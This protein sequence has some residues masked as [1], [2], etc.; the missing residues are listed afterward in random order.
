MIATAIVG[1]LTLLSAG[2]TAA[3]GAVIGGRGSDESRSAT[4]SLAVEGITGIEIDSNAAKLSLTYGDVAEAKLDV[5]GARGGEWLLSREDDELKV[6]SPRGLFG[7]ISFCFMAC[8]AELQTVTLTLPRELKERSIDVDAALGAG[9]LIADGN[10][11]DVYVDLSAGRATL[12][13]SARSLELDMSAGD[14]SG[15][16]SSVRKASFTVSAGNAKAAFTGVAPREVDVDVTAGSVDLRL[17]NDAYRV[18]TDV[19]A[20]SIDNRLRTDPASKNLIT[21]EATAGEI[22]LRPEK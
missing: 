16:L 8:S 4:T 13:G 19:T 11:G 2:A 18:E 14:F 20:G 7:G 6:E 9:E 5:K 15:E 22:T 1:G 10:F 12:T 17:P 21:V 3:L